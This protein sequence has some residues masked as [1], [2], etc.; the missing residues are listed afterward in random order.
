VLAVLAC[1]QAWP[2]AMRGGSRKMAR[3]PGKGGV[4]PEFGLVQK[5]RGGRGAGGGP[6]ATRG[7]ISNPSCRPATTIQPCPGDAVLTWRSWGPCGSNGWF[8]ASC[9]HWGRRKGNRAGGDGDR[10]VGDL[11]RPGQAH[12]TMR[13]PPACGTRAGYQAHQRRQEPTC[14]PCRDA[15]A[16]YLRQYRGSTARPVQP[17]GTPAAYRRHRAHG[18]I[19]CPA[20]K[21]AWGAYLRE[22]KG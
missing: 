2:G 16:E 20:C 12:A 21:Q 8:S 6:L 13:T 17:C 22:R 1:L 10:G 7:T 14:Q 5:L 19:P 18:E 11:R 3:A 9:G 15:H 4:G